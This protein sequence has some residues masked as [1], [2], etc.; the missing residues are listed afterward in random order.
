[1]SRH[2]DLAKFLHVDDDTQ[3]L[4]DEPTPALLREMVAGARFAAAT[5]DTLVALE[6]ALD[7]VGAFRVSLQPFL[8]ML[9]EMRAVSGEALQQQFKAG[10]IGLEGLRSLLQ[11]LASYQ[12]QIS[13]LQVCCPASAL[14]LCVRALASQQDTVQHGPLLGASDHS[15]IGCESL[16]AKWLHTACR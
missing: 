3:W 8:A 6:G 12:S 13:E 14:L 15:C 2:S 5:Q 10:D 9:Q 4:L 1:M 7:E 11:T 16:V